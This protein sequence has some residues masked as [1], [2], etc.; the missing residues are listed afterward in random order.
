[1][2][3]S[4]TSYGYGYPWSFTTVSRSTSTRPLPDSQE[5]WKKAH[6]QA[7]T[8]QDDIQG[9][10]FDPTLE[11]YKPQLHLSIVKPPEAPKEVL[12][13]IELPIRDH[14][15]HHNSA[16]TAKR[17]ITQLNACCNWACESSLLAA[18]P[19]KGM[20]EKINVVQDEKEIDPF[21]P[22]ERDA[23]IQGFEQHPTYCYYV[24]FV[25]FLFM[26]GCRTSEAVGLQWKHISSSCSQ[27]T[28]TE[29]VVCVSS[30]K[31]RKNTKTG[32]SR[33]LACNTQL[34][35]LLLSIKP[36]NC[37]PE[38]CPQYNTRHTFITMAIEANVS[39]PQVAKW[40]NNSSEIIMQHYAGT[41]RQFQV[42]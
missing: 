28:F 5:G 14:L 32:K 18:N 41:L 22:A 8:I 27:I 30:H 7:W 23:I 39:V 21:F 11:K 16:Y 29:A 10:N 36:E 3:Y 33:K 37:D 20:A 35:E 38:A 17:V 15:L 2:R 6:T 25:R 4:G 42:P 19:F 31:I 1:M 12:T 26:T 13:L 24:P 34:Q 9:G 40:V